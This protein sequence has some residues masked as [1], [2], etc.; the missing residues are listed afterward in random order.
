[1]HIIYSVLLLIYGKHVS[2][3]FSLQFASFRTI[4]GCAP[5]EVFGTCNAQNSAHQFH[6][7]LTH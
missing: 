1:M 4:S 3:R 2:C 5:G 7:S 6:S